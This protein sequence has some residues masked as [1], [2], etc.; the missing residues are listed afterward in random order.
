MAI[1]SS[2]GRNGGAERGNERARGRGWAESSAE[3]GGG[4]SCRH[5]VE[6]VLTCRIELIEN[7]LL[8]RGSWKE[9]G[10]L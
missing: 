6:L 4:R 8:R 1:R 2:P 7:W 9:D 10:V 3:E 5:G